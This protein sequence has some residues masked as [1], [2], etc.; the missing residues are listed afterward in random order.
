[1]ISSDYIMESRD[2][3]KRLEMKTEFEA[4]KEQAVWAGLVPG[5]RVADMGCGS[6]IT[7]SFLKEITGPSGEVVGVDRSRDR[8][9]YARQNYGNTGVSFIERD[10]YHPLSDLGKFD[11]IWVR[12]LLEYHR[13]RQYELVGRFSELLA[14]GGILCLVDLDF[15]SINHYGWSGRLKRAI[16]A[17]VSSLEMNSDFDPYAGKR[18]YGHLYDLNLKDIQVRMAAHHLIYGKLKN[19]DEFNWLT[20]VAVACRDSGYSYPEYP[21]GFDEFYQECRDFFSDPRR[22]TY[23]P[24]I[25]CRG[26]C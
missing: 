23:T 14:P 2:E 4:L 10:I 26:V 17:I 19:V 12:F 11:F 21:G 25:L 5:M 8:L 15:N 22:F 16:E 20:K 3:V 7:T 13:T 6:G 18:L 24:L 1:M 9:E